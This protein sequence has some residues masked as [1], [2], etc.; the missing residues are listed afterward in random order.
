MKKYNQIIE[1]TNFKKLDRF[2][3]ANLFYVV[4]KN[5]N[6][7][8]NINKTIE[9]VNLEN[10]SSNFYT[11]YEVSATDSWASIS[12]VFYKTYKLWWI[13]CKFNNIKNPF[14]EL[15]PGKLIKIPNKDLVD[16]ILTTIGNNDVY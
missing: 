8:F 9:F 15:T 5:E 7:Y 12:F 1:L 10:T 2:D 3:F 16:S 14:T 4:E 6:S 13:I 11:V